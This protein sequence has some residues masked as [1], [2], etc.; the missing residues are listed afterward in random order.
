MS[1]SR[2]SMTMSICPNVASS[3]ASCALSLTGWRANER[4]RRS[5][6]WLNRSPMM[7]FLFIS[8][9][10]RG[11]MLMYAGGTEIKLLEIY[12]KQ[13]CLSLDGC[14][15][16]R[17]WLNRYSMMSLLCI[18]SCIQCLPVSQ[19][20]EGNKIPAFVT[21]CLAGDRCICSWLNMP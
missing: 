1:V 6:S 16:N 18:S 17:S 12:S 2:W 7:S 13:H 5:R 9:C 11:A 21:H 3:S 19:Q 4:C 20:D 8:S 15:R 14:R 10:S